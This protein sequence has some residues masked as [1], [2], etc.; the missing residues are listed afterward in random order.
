MF[1]KGSDIELIVW[2]VLEKE[3]GLFCGEFFLE[4]LRV[5][6]ADSEAYESSAVSEDG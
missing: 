1:G 2:E 5:F 6:A 3:I 4:C